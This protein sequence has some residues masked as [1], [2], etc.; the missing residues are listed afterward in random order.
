MRTYVYI[1]TY[2]CIYTCTV[3]IYTYIQYTVS[4]QSN[5]AAVQLNLFVILER[6]L[7]FGKLRLPV[8]EMSNLFFRFSADPARITNTAGLGGKLGGRR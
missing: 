5:N 2:I 8:S 7:H 4:S 1:R 3:F 6:S